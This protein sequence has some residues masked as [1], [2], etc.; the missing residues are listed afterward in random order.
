MDA[1]D[2]GSVILYSNDGDEYRLVG[3]MPQDG[4]PVTTAMY[5]R[6]EKSGSYLSVGSVFFQWDPS[7]EGVKIV[8]NDNWPKQLKEEQKGPSSFLITLID[9][10]PSA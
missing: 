7:T 10:K 5:I 9:N 6:D 8:E 1:H 2:V 3:M 4:P